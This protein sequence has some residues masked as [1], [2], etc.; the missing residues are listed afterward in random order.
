M[1][2][3]GFFFYFHMCDRSPSEKIDK[4]SL[5]SKINFIFNV[6]SIEQQTFELLPEHRFSP[7][8]I[9][10]VFCKASQAVGYKPLRH[11]YTTYTFVWLLSLYIY[12]YKVNTD[13]T[14]SKIVTLTY[15]HPSPLCHFLLPLFPFPP[16]PPG[17]LLW[18]IADPRL[19]LSQS[20]YVKFGLNRIFKRL[21]T[22]WKGRHCIFDLSA[23]RLH[24]SIEGSESNQVTWLKCVISG[25]KWC[26]G[27]NSKA[28]FFLFITFSL[29]FD[30]VSSNLKHCMQ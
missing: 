29:V 1:S 30:H 9:P 28:C 26:S 2:E 17:P 4:S 20:Y 22:F 23:D 16:P 15:P 14:L 12:I 7:N 24:G 8:N 25:R 6:K 21:I 10:P 5:T 3:T 19:L 27:R 18:K 13:K 11:L